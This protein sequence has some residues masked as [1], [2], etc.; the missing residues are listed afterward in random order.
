MMTHAGQQIEKECCRGVSQAVLYFRLCGPGVVDRV[1]CAGL[2]VENA[3]VF[4]WGRILCRSQK[5]KARCALGELWLGLHWSRHGSRGRCL[6]GSWSRR[7]DVHRSEPRRKNRYYV[8]CRNGRWDIG[9][10]KNRHR[11]HRSI[12]RTEYFYTGRCK[13]ASDDDCRQQEYP[14]GEPQQVPEATGGGRASGRR[15]I[16]R[17]FQSGPVHVV[18][19]VI[20]GRTHLVCSLSWR[21]SVLMDPPQKI[22]GRGDTPIS[23]HSSPATR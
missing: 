20:V 4:K 1:H 11:R 5:K 21:D 14:C 23:P 8:R 7:R 3:W 19:R 10:N 12:A 6:D 22:R 2:V 16:G 13:D 9:R 17:G 18:K 15:F